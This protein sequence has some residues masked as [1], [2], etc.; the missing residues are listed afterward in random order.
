MF[1]AIA[2]FALLTTFAAAA[3]DAILR[4]RE[5]YAEEATREEIS[6]L[7][8]TRNGLAAGFGV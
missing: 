5:V 2:T 3:S 8:F 7:Q 1:A 4:G 6:S